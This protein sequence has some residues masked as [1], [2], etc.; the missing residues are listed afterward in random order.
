MDAPRIPALDGLRIAAIGLLLLAHGVAVFYTV[1]PQQRLIWFLGC[2]GMDIFFVLAGFLLVRSVLHDPALPIVDRLRERFWRIG[3]NYGLF[4][5]VGVA[6]AALTDGV[7]HIPLRYWLFVQNFARPHPSFLPELW[8]IAT[9]VSSG[10]ILLVGY[11]TLVRKG[12]Y[13]AA[14]TLI[15]AVIVAANLVRVWHVLANDPLWDEGVKKITVLRFDALAYGML[16]GHWHGMVWSTRVRPGG[17]A[18]VAIVMLVLAFMGFALT[19]ENHSLFSR[20]LLFACDGIG[21]A[22]LVLSLVVLPPPLPWV[23]A[24]FSYGA[25]RSYALFLCHLPIM[26]IM[27]MFH[28]P[29]DRWMPCLLQAFVI[30]ASSGVTAML[31]YRFWE[32]RW[33]CRSTGYSGP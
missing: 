20:S 28:F 32:R 13:R 30:A 9:A 5:L 2:W 4:L 8:G 11:A 27:E 33:L 14:L 25:N 22:A 7:W 1:F 3:P 23:S 6:L 29:R 24:F 10:A 26:R 15:A 18:L 21:F 17:W 31:V 19:D 16:A 12:R